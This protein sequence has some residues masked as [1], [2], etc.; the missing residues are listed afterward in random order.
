MVEKFSFFH[1]LTPAL[2]FVLFKILISFVFHHP[3][4]PDDQIN[5]LPACPTDTKPQK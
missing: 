4:K 1:S 5:G 3:G 2:V